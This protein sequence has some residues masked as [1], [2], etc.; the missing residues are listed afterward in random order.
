MTLLTRVAAA[1]L[2][3]ALAVPALAEPLAPPAIRAAAGELAALLQRDYL[4]PDVGRRYA[5]AL[6]ERA[7]AGAYDGMGDPAALAAAWEGELRA[8][9]ADAHLRVLAT[10]PAA[11]QPAAMQ[12]LHQELK[13]F[14]AARWLGDGV[15]YLPIQLLPGTEEAVAQ[16]AAFLDEYAGAHTLVLDL[17]ACLGGALPVMDELFARLYGNPVRLVRMDTRERSNDAVQAMFDELPSLRREPAPAGIRR[18]DHWAAPRD[19]AGPWA[20]AKVYLLTDVTASACEHLTYALKLTGRATQV[21]ATTRG[22]GHYGGFNRFG[23]QFEVFVPVGRTYDVATGKGWETTGIAPDIAAAPEDALKVALADA[24][25]DAAAAA[26]VPVPR[27]PARVVAG[28]PAQK[29]YGM[30]LEPPRGGETALPVVEVPE[31]TIAARA[32]LRRGDRILRLNGKPV[33]ELGAAEIPGYLRG[34]PL[35]L[36]VERDGAELTI[37]MSLDDAP[38]PAG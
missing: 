15:A 17:R 8:I 12:R 23:R 24:G 3:I 26:S 2:S 33:A 34:S 4:F 16:M 11:G 5:A 29:R 13:A 22:A 7:A 19:P 30:A 37:R 32:G 28:S 20:K 10:D 27:P 25:L 31:G 9:H 1:A 35:E 36:V 21:G 18:Y 38:A 6:R 14:G